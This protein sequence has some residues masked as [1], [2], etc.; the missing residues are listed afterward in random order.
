[1]AAVSPIPAGGVVGSQSAKPSSELT[2]LRA[3]CEY[4]LAHPRELC[5]LP[6][7]KVPRLNTTPA[8][9]RKLFWLSMPPRVAKSGGLKRVC[10]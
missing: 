6:D 5:Y 10:R 2:R 7:L 3:N 8:A 4:N 9:K 1:M